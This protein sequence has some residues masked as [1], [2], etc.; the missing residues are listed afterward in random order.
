[1]VT[2]KKIKE[3]VTET[4]WSKL[5]VSAGI[6]QCMIVIGL[7]VS[8]CYLNSS[9]A[10]LLPKNTNS[11]V[12]TSNST[13]Y[14]PQQAAD[15]LDRIKWENIAFSSFQ[16]WFIYMV[17]D[18]TTYQNT[19]E[20]LALAILNAACAILGA[21]QVVDCIRW[22]RR[23]NQVGSP[24][25]PLVIAEKLEVTLSAVLLVFAVIMSFLSFQMSKQFGWNIY[26]KIGADVRIQ[27][28]RNSLWKSIIQVIV[29]L[30]ILPMLYFAR[31]A[32]STEK[33]FHFVLILYQTLQPQ[34]HWYTWIVLVFIGVLLDIASSVLGLICMCH[35]NKGLKPFVQRGNRKGD[36]EENKK[37]NWQIDED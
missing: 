17:F 4:R 21:L 27:K 2:I 28:G 26:K 14:I 15:R 37:E 16:C 10:D 23:L 18:A 5:Y 36:L 12:L 30:L 13:E 29:T 1:M 25:G 3:R 19:A 34:D 32:G 24:V 22:L 31:T 33:L 11:N 8:I 6:L 9:E 35:F 20:I 7:Q